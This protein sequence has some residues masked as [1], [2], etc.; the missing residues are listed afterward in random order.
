MDTIMTAAC[1]LPDTQRKIDSAARRG[2][3]WRAGDGAKSHHRTEMMERLPQ[4]GN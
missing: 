2:P 4:R 3:F 1:I